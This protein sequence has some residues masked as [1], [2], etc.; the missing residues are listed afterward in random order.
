MIY[1]IDLD[2]MIDG[3]DSTKCKLVCS[4]LCRIKPMYGVDPD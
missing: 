4:T 3:W 2:P 1:L